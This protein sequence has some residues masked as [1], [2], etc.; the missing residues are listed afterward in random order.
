MVIQCTGEGGFTVVVKGHQVDN[1]WVVPYCPLLTKASNSHI[2]VEYCHSVRSIKYVCKYINKGTDAATFGIRQEGSVDEIQDF[3]AGRVISSTEGLWHIF[4]FPNHECFPAIV[5]LAVHLENDELLYFS[6]NTPKAHR[7][8]RS[9]NFVDRTSFQ[10][11]TVPRRAFILRVGK[12]K[13]LCSPEV[14]R[15]LSGRQKDARLGRVFTVP[16]SRQECFYLNVFIR[17]H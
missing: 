4:S 10:D 9:S 3:L 17:L 13:N 2:N 12:K 16:P 1:R 6:A 8:Q 7:I 5:Q 14:R 11:S 15:G